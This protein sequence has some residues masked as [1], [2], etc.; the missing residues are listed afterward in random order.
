MSS[1]ASVSV[2]AR[3]H[4]RSVLSDV[5]LRADGGKQS[6]VNY[7]QVNLVD[8]WGLSANRLRSGMVDA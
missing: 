5:D 2:S 7:C 3:T 8:K 6:L 4:A 1:E